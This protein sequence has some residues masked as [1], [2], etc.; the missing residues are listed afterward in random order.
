[1]AINICPQCKTPN[2]A[3]ARFCSECGEP[4]ISGLPAAPGADAAI[5]DEAATLAGPG[6]T[7]KAD[8]QSE[9]TLQSRYRLES[10]LGRGGFGAV[11][12]AWDLNISRPCAVKENL[13]PSLEA[14]RQ[15][16]R[17]AS[18]LANLS[19][20]HLP[21]VTDHFSIPGKGQYLVMD[22]VDGEDLASILE[23]DKEVPVQQ[24]VEWAL[25]VADALEYL[26]EQEPPVLHRDIKPANIRITRKNRAMLVDFG[27][28]KLYSPGMQTTLGARAVTPGY[29]PPEQYGKG[30]TDARTDI[31]AL[32]ATLYHILTGVEPLESVQRVSGER[33]PPPMQLNPK[34]PAPLSQAIE[35]ALALDPAQRF[36]SVREFRQAL[37]ASLEPPIGYVQPERAEALSTY[38]AADASAPA[39]AGRPASQPTPSRP[40]SAPQGARPASHP[41]ARPASQPRPE[42]R[43]RWLPATAITAVIV[44]C[45][46]AALVVGGILLSSGPSRAE[47]TATVQMQRTLEAGLRATQTYIYEIQATQTAAAQPPP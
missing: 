34:I 11:Y 17:E 13:D 20:P 32:G 28:V 4:L 41:A 30:K 22:Y 7:L 23:R 12:K 40:P 24:A 44:L 25:Q 39:L 9:I 33:M 18:V 3:S 14:A 31:Y 46:L 19:H 6:S 2:R 35:R 36:Q 15:F 21:R 16:A 8:D 27:L 26:H 43:K 29:A 47:I 1:M 45:L 38:P 42:A 5:E 37:R 10:E